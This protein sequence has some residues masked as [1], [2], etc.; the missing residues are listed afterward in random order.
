MLAIFYPV[1]NPH[2]FVPENFE[3][4]DEIDILEIMLSLE[5]ESE[6]SSVHIYDFGSADKNT[7]YPNVKD[8]Q[9]DY[10]AEDLDG[11]FFVQVLP[12]MTKQDIAR[13]TYKDKSC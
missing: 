12:T 9:N 6:F 10:N 3:G 11:G 4:K 1:D 7:F 8:F 2:E 5:E 13:L